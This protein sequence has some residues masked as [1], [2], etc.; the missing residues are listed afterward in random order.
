MVATMGAMRALCSAAALASCAVAA[1][2]SGAGS[3]VGGLVAYVVR[4]ADEVTTS[5]NVVAS[6][7]TGRRRLVEGQE[8]AWAPEGDRF[9]FARW[10]P[11]PGGIDIY[12]ASADG[13]G[14]RALLTAA[15][16]E[17]HPSWSPDGRRIAYMESDRMAE[18]SA[19]MRLRVVDVA[20][21]ASWTVAVDAFP[22]GSA[23]WSP[24]GTQ[25]VYSALRRPEPY[26]IGSDL[27]QVAADGSG[28][29]R[30][31]T[32][33]RSDQ[34]GPIIERAPRWA[35]DG[36]SIAFVRRPGNP[37]YPGEL[38]VMR[39]DG[40]GERRLADRSGEFSWSPDSTRIVF[41]RDPSHG[42]S[43]CG[44][45]ARPLVVVTVASG[46][47]RVLTS[48]NSEGPPAWSPDGAKIAFL[49]DRDDSAELYVMNSDGTCELRRTNHGNNDR[50]VERLA[51]Q[52][53]RSSG[54]RLR[55][56]DVHVAG[57]AV[58]DSSQL[59]DI[60]LGDRITYRLEVRNIG[61][62][63]ATDVRLEVLAEKPSTL[64]VTAVTVAGATCKTRPTVTCRVARMR[65]AERRSVAV[66]IRASFA[67][68]DSYIRSSDRVLLV[69]RLFVRASAP[70]ESNVAN[71]V[72]GIRQ[73]VVP[74]SIEGTSRSESLRG[75]MARDR[76]CAREGEDTIT[77]AGGDDVIDAGVG[78][79]TV[80]PGKGR[81]LVRGRGGADR[82]RA[83]DGQRDVIACG[84]GSDRVIADRVDRL[85]DCEHVSIR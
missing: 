36:R 62:L 64:D 61:N 78:A 55:C 41:V 18:F 12:L 11:S 28:A 32:T 73:L 16:D 29:G 71:N 63:A 47:S 1:A 79:D 26:L 25:L 38:W 20:T 48:T 84:R 45:S 76:I 81:D 6:D 49:S 8:L 51:W 7:G 56:T 17:V 19:P 67:A 80:Y 13:T 39:A 35:P 40:T 82:I 59:T 77:A 3:D 83:A 66:S 14:V 15:A 31:L 54:P 34:H 75:T 44:D 53:G 21:R 2:A 72:L 58:P 70:G 33:T 37:N 50:S 30:D 9:A 27:V 46:Q 23:Q 42:C 4:D 57:I 43:R 60:K 69:E 24:D 85:I 5:I 52:P 10:T 65:P 68:A 74:C 22:D